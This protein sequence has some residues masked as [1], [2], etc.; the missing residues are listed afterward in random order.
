MNQNIAIPRSPTEKEL[1]KL[2][3][4]LNENLRPNV[5][6]SIQDEYPQVFQR[7]NLHNLKIVYKDDQPITHAALKPI[8]IKTPLL[9]YK[10]AAIGSVVTHPSFRGQ[11]LSSQAVEA[12]LEEANNQDCDLAILWTDL[13]QHYRK[14]GFELAGFE[15]YFFI[16]KPLG[17]LIP[18]QAMPNQEYRFELTTQVDPSAILRLY[19]KHSVT[20]HRTIDDIKKFLK[21]PKTQLYTAWDKN[22]QLVAYAAEG[23]GADLSRVIHEWGG[24]VTGMIGLLN[25]SFNKTNSPLTLMVGSQ[26]INLIS[27]LN[28]LGLAPHIGYLGMIHILNIPLF[29]QKIER[30]LRSPDLYQFELRPLNDGQ[31]LWTVNG[32]TLQLKTQHELIQYLF[33]QKPILGFSSKNLSAL[34]KHFP[35][36]LWIWGWDSI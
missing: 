24:S 4:F 11:G 26:S 36:P 28:S 5:S 8:I 18:N 3:E 10:I 31:I 34:N 22:N 12:C 1:P 30:A 27:H 21:I 35:L 32:E 17:G 16:D 20:S 25:W 13:H 23:K 6:W 2:I 19:N 7:R 9:L 15:E 29:G 33:G 14:Y